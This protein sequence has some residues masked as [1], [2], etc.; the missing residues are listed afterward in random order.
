METNN[1]QIPWGGILLGCLIGG[2]IVHDMSRKKAAKVA[3]QTAAEKAEARAR[4][5]ALRMEANEE[6]ERESRESTLRMEVSEAKQQ[7]RELQEKPPAPQA[8][9]KPDKMSV[10]RRVDFPKP[11]K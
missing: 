9:N 2:A 11:R 10:S 1:T 7:P 5:N 3:E 8:K 6:A 4:E